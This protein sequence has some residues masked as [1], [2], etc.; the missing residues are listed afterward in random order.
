MTAWQREGTD[1][2]REEGIREEA[3][4][5]RGRRCAD[6]RLGEGDGSKAQVHPLRQT[7]RQ[8]QMADPG[9]RSTLST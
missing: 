5:C 7:E 9:L 2:E 1:V 3:S 4:K 8:R 6:S